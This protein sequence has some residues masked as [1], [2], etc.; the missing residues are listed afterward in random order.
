MKADTVGLAAL[1]G[2]AIGVELRFDGRL[3]LG[4]VATR[5][6]KPTIDCLWPVIGGVPGRPADD[7]VT[8]LV[9]ARRDCGGSGVASRVI[10]L[11]A[12]VTTTS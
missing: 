9:V 8:R 2:S 4:D 3:N 12:V 11:D 1:F 6:L 7:L 10:E 5:R